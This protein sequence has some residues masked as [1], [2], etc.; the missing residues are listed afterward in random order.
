M[1]L[2]FFFG[3]NSQRSKVLTFKTQQNETTK[4]RDMYFPHFI[5]NLP[6]IVILMKITQVHEF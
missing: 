5:S 1:G 3:I 6:Q 4:L 2:F